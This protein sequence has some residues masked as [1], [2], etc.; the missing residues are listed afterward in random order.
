MVNNGNLIRNGGFE[1]GTFDFWTVV[2]GHIVQS[3]DANI[4]G[5]Y[6]AQFDCGVNVFTACSTTDLLPVGP[7]REYEISFSLWGSHADV[8]TYGLQ[9]CNQDGDIIRNTQ[10]SIPVVPTDP[11]VFTRRHVTGAG[12]AYAILNIFSASE[13]LGDYFFL[14][15]ISVFELNGGLSADI[16]AD[17]AAIAS[18][19]KTPTRID[20][21]GITS[22]PENGVYQGVVFNPTGYSRLDLFLYSSG[23]QLAGSTIAVTL[24]VQESFHPDAWAY[25]SFSTIGASQ[26]YQK[27]NVTAVPPFPA[28]IQYTVAGAPTPSGGSLY[29]V[30]Y[31][32]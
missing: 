21:V 27:L 25:Q 16:A 14:N 22:F 29:V 8:I 15:D 17:I 30:G 4:P 23:I 32:S 6:E 10:Y 7:N 11:T 31:L 3:N 2:G 19:T 26:T 1:T 5:E 28:W 18:T 24:A 9:E 12:A 20:M 13:S